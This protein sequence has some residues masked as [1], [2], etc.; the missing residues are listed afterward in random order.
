MTNQ[1]GFKDVLNKAKLYL[2]E[3]DL[4]L[5]QEAYVFA[6]KA[7]EGQRRQSKKPYITHPIAVASILCD[8]EQEAETIIGGLLHDTIEDTDVTS[9]K[10]KEKFGEKISV[11][12]DGV[13]K[14]NKLKFFSLSDEYIKG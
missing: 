8:L 10:I 7:H 11:L 13:T 1:H 6:Q 12:V 9:K 2:K 14:L 5:L 3:A 4:E